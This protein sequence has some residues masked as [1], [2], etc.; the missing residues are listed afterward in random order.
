MIVY[1]NSFKAH[2]ITSQMASW[3]HNNNHH[4]LCFRSR[5]CKRVDTFLHSNTQPIIESS[6]T[7]KFTCLEFYYKQLY[8]E[9]PALSY[10]LP[11]THS[12]FFHACCSLS[13]NSQFLTFFILSPLIELL[14][15]QFEASGLS[16][17][18]NEWSNVFD[19]S[20]VTDMQNFSLLPQVCV[21]TF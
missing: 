1:S 14:S 3:S 2:C 17:Y 6:S 20:P 8:G 11:K 7:M 4:N 10:F 19:F 12:L 5:D 9:C 16:M 18:N 15:D 13:P 21:K